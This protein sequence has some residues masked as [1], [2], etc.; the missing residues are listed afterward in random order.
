MTHETT[1]LA[2]EYHHTHNIFPPYPTVHTHASHFHTPFYISSP[3]YSNSYTSTNTHRIIIRKLYDTHL[4][5]HP[6]PIQTP[7]TID[8]HFSPTRLINIIVAIYS[9]RHCNIPSTT[10]F[11]SIRGATYHSKPLIPT[12]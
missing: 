12:N 2:N 7:N 9:T 11:H 10:L 8:T 1:H 6:T 3:T 5:P 4:T